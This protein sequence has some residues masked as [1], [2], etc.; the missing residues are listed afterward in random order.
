LAEP[1]EVVLE[2]L[3]QL[4]AEL[5]DTYPIKKDINHGNFGIHI[6]DGQTLS[7]DIQRSRIG[8]RLN[9]QNELQ[10]V[11]LKT[12]GFTFS[13]LEPYESWDQMEQEAKRLWDIYS[14][15]STP[16]NITRVATRFINVMRIPMDGFVDF[17]KVLTAAPQVP[18]NLPQGIASFLTR[19]VIPYTEHN[20]AAIVT[21]AFEALDNNYI[22]IL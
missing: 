15:A 17:D 14:N 3:N 19:V 2:K 18:E 22:P 7:T 16:V 10:I 11:Q 12:S 8:V 13:R 1:P 20:G 5:E 9:S 4:A 21:Q 6:N